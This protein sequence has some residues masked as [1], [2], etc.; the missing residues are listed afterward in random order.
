MFG[1]YTYVCIS[2]SNTYIGANRAYQSRAIETSQQSSNSTKGRTT[3]YRQH[4]A[5]ARTSRLSSGA[6]QCKD[7]HH[8]RR[9]TYVAA[10]NHGS[11]T[12]GEQAEEDMTFKRRILH[13]QGKDGKQYKA[14]LNPW[15][16]SMQFFVLGTVTWDAFEPTNDE[17]RNALRSMMMGVQAEVEQ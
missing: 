6:V 3:N 13:W 14:I 9:G 11:G 17:L 15:Y 7:I 10:S 4:K 1:T 16:D 12:A 2:V 8:Q 5:H